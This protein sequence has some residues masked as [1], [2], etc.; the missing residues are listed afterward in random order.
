V[1]TRKCAVTVNFCDS[2]QWDKQP[3]TRAAP[4]AMSLAAAR[5]CR[6]AP[7]RPARPPAAEC[8]PDG[9][10]GALAR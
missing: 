7:R 3:G 1:P 5:A 10:A 8:M 9:G 6:A 2:A 4:H